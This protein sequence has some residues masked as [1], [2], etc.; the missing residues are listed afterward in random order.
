[1]VDRPVT[2]LVDRKKL[3]DGIRADI[4]H[5]HFTQKQVE[6]IDAIVDA[7][8]ESV[9]DDLRWLAYMLAT[10]YHETAATMQPIK[11][12]GD[13]NYF[14][15]MYGPNGKR[16]DTARKMGNVL[17]GDGAKYCGRGY[18]Q[19]TWEVNYKHASDITGV[20][21]V[22]NPDLALRPDIAAKVMFAGMTDAKIIFE[23]FSDTE[24]FTFTGKSLEDYFSDTTDDPIGA[25]R[26]INGTDHASLI[27]DTYEDFL[28]HLDYRTS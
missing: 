22:G 12:Y 17:P 13:F 18:V 16:P 6:G 20:D 10:T 28:K 15:R 24:N 26:I 14:E 11:E 19:M 8:D 7:W 5:G 4:F 2:D 3:F 23:D 27:A 25:R 21:L 1:M 9:F